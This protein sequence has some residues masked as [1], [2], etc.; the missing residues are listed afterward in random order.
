[1]PALRG[2]ELAAAIAGGQPLS[3]IELT[4]RE[5]KYHQVKR[6]FEAVGKKVLYLRRVGM[7]PLPLDTGLAPGEWRE[8]TEEE[9]ASLRSANPPQQ[10]RGQRP[11]EP[12]TRE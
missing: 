1:V 7:G 10:D 3:W 11:A 5:G 8:L 9:V 2:E 12:K 6:M 4:I